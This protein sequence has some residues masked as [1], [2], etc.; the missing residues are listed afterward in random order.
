LGRLGGIVASRHDLGR[1][2][3]RIVAFRHNSGRLREGIVAFRHDSGKLR[4]GIVAFG[5]DS[6]GLGGIVASRRVLAGTRGAFDGSRHNQTGLRRGIKRFKY[7]GT[8]VGCRTRFLACILGFNS[9]K[10]FLLDLS[11]LDLAVLA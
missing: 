11:I 6:G 7:I 9:C 4:E 3:E 5:H 10:A 2:G 1:L 8:L